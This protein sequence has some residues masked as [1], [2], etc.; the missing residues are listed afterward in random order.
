M[1]ILTIV[2]GIAA[3]SINKKL[4]DLI[5]PLAPA[6]FEF[7]GFD[8]TTLPYFSQDIEQNPPQPVIT[9]REKIT[10]ASGVLFVTPEY[11]RSIPGVL[12]NAID[13]P[14]RPY[15]NNTWKGKCAGTLGASMGAIGTFGAQTQLRALLSFLDMRVMYQPELYFNFVAFVK[16]AEGPKGRPQLEEK[17]Q[18]FFTA[19]LAAFREWI[20]KNG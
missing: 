15:G 1:K 6:D 11:N 8:I 19:Y 4:L 17:S 16:P 9:L 13:W 18:K 2:G 7:T 14:S 3:N 20:V 5:K 12:K 10:A